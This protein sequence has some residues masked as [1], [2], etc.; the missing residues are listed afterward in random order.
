MPDI[1]TNFSVFLPL[2]GYLLIP[3]T[4]VNLTDYDIVRRGVYSISDILQFDG[5]IYG[6]WGRRGLTAS[7]SR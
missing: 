5:G 4:A 6:R 7:A 2:L 3:W 1:L